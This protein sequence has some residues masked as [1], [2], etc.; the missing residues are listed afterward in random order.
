MLS[1][2]LDFVAD[3]MS[4]CPALLDTLKDAQHRFAQL[5]KRAENC[6]EIDS[7]HAQELYVPIGNS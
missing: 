6:P 1:L 2:L 5:L 3:Q 4:T 7:N